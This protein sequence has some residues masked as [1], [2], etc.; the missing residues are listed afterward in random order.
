MEKSLPDA[1][2]A[3][4]STTAAIVAGYTAIGLRA[5]QCPD[6]DRRRTA[7]AGL[8]MDGFGRTIPRTRAAFHASVAVHKPGLIAIQSKY[9]V[10][11][12]GKTH[13]AASA[14]LSIEFK[15]HDIR[16]IS[17][18]NHDIPI[19]HPYRKRPTIHNTHPTTNATAC[20]GT[21]NRISRRTPDNDV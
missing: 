21:A 19:V 2:Q 7:D 10:R 20:S 13:R 11:T 5:A 17:H 9:A 6:D 3:T 16:Q 18:S 15:R 4:R 12:D 14:F 1:R 8:D